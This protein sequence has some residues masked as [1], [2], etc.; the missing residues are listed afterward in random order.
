MAY[1][2]RTCRYAYNKK[3]DKQQI[4]NPVIQYI[5][6]HPSFNPGKQHQAP[7]YYP[8]MIDMQAKM[9]VC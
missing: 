4:L 8:F 6:R 1:R 7:P 2:K 3:K 9:R 5:H